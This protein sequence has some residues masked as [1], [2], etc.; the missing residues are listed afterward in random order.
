MV[1]HYNHPGQPAAEFPSLD[2][3]KIKMD[4]ALKKFLRYYK[5]LIFKIWHHISYFYV[6]GLNWGIKWKKKKKNMYLS[7]GSTT[8]QFSYT[9]L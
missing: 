2:T 7:D 5:K 8:K 1:K 6:T 4:V 3:I 9:Y